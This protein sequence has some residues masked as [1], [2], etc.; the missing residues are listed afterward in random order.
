M[1]SI[2]KH[3]LLVLLL[4]SGFSCSD[5]FLLLSPQQSIADEE[6]LIAFSDFEA[7]IVGGYDQLQSSDLYG[8]YIPLV[9]DVM[10]E[11]VKQNA[12]A[13]RAKEWAEY[14]GASV[15]FIPRE[16]WAEL[17]EIVNITNRIINAEF[18]PIES[19]Q[20]RFNQI[21]GEAHA[22]RAL[23][24]FDLCRLFAQHYTFTTDAG[25]PGVPLVLEFNPFLKPK[26]NTVAE[27]YTQIIDDFEEAIDLINNTSSSAGTF[28]KEGAQ[29]L[30]SRVYLY[31]EEY[32]LSEDMATE[33][34]NSGRFSLVDSANYA[35]QFFEGNSSEAIFE[36]VYNL[37]D[38]PGSDHLGGMYKAN[39]YGDYLPSTDLLSLI[40]DGDVRSTIFAEDPDLSGIYGNLRINKYPSDSTD[41]ATDN[42]PVIRLSEVYLNR[43]EAR[44]KKAAPDFAG[45][46]ADLNL[47]RQRGWSDAPEVIASGD[48]LID[49][50]LI[51]RRIELAFEG[52]RIFDAT[53]NKQDII[54]NDCTAPESACSIMYPNDR[55]ILPI[56]Q[57][58]TNVNGEIDQNQSYGR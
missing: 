41:I 25:H 16:F 36:M 28:S 9:A 5:D 52:H 12:S 22:I 14:N 40:S 46:R 3:I 50:I 43:A 19:N 10:G 7:A 38:N 30:L 4:S 20:A 55:F 13:N 53:R 39:G 27:V 34:I 11:D 48:A 32:D 2:Y 44:A 51:E 24:Y 37:V 35:N 15:D 49:Q 17:Y 45:A 23:A 54:R 26:R 42:L 31:M 6:F 8:R 21:V 33:V 29:A 18:T 47:I 58:E 56:P 57:N 1:K